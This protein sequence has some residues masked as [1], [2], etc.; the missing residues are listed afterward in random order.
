M[1]RKECDSSAP[2]MRPPPGYKWRPIFTGGTTYLYHAFN[3]PV[4]ATSTGEEILTNFRDIRAQIREF[5]G[6]TFSCP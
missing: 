5:I 3:D 6:L 4:Q 1:Q 2:I